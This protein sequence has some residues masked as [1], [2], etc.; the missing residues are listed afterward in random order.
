MIY[1]EILSLYNKYKGRKCVIGYSFR[2]LAIFAFHVG[3][4]FGR[5]YISTYA[6]HGREWITA[7]LAAWHI[8]HPTREGG[9][10]I[11]LVNPDGAVISQGT[12]P[13][14]K[15]NARGVDLNV[16][17]DAD[18][19]T[20]AYNTTRRGASDCIGDAPFSESESL[21][22]AAFT[23]KISPYVT[24]SFHTKGGEIY[25]EYG[26]RGD[27]RG[28]RLLAE[29]TG[30]A[31][32]RIR[33]SAGGYKDWCIQKLGIPAYTIECGS[34]GLAHPITRVRALKCCRKALIYFTENYEK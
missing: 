2:G 20:G 30:Y 29:A 26:G 10:I 1:S 3:D 7:R 17:F 21:A 31:V 8:S 22:L 5:Q 34:D 6:I 24:F 28:A 27:E 15:A 32:K 16:N 33:G 19:G 12:C 4:P 13:M 18:W 23:R 14:W 9:W 25:W 11:P